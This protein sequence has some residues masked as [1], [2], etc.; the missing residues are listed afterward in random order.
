MEEII[1]LGT[2]YAC[3][4]AFFEG[5]AVHLYN[6]RESNNS[7]VKQLNSEAI[8]CILEGNCVSKR[9]DDD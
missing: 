4:S 7:N 8:K 5:N 2:K 3:T 9:N 6:S 1:S